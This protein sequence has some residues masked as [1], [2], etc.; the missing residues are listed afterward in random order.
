MLR[1]ERIGMATTNTQASLIAF[2]AHTIE[3][4]QKEQLAFGETAS[5]DVESALQWRA[6]G[7]YVAVYTAR[8]AKAALDQVKLGRDLRPIYDNLIDRL[9]LLASGSNTQAEVRAIA[10]LARSLKDWL[11]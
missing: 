5:K 4:A 1:A 6:E 9:L 2:L 3:S 10:A 7:A 11:S 8:H